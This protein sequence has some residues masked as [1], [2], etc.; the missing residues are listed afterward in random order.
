MEALDYKGDNTFQGGIGYITAKFEL[1][2][3]GEA[4]VNVTITENG[5]SN[6][7]QGTKLLKY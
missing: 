5:K 4:N 2:N 7:I 1:L 3:N 6:D